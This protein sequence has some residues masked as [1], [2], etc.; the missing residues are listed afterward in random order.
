MRKNVMMR[1]LAAGFLLISL[2]FMGCA[3]LVAGGAGAGATY[4]Y[5]QGWLE[6]DYEVPFDR[7][8]AATAAAIK[9]LEM[10][11]VEDVREV[12]SAKIRAEKGDQQNWI[13]VTT[14]GEKLSSISVRVGLLGDE[15]A[16]ELIHRE[17]ERNL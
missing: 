3:A 6:R 16:S 8:Y 7:A 4:A 2:T 10:R 15:K 1:Y 13:T 11:V 14:K 17:I 12:G 9:N 5:L